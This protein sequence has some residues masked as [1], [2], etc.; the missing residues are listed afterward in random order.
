MDLFSKLKEKWDIIA[1]RRY[2]L[3]LEDQKQNKDE[4]FESMQKI[5]LTKENFTVFR[6]KKVE[7]TNNNNINNN[8]Y[9]FHRN[10]IQH[11]INTYPGENIVIFEDDCRALYSDKA[12]KILLRAFNAILKRK[13]KLLNLGQ[14][15]LSPC[16]HLGNNIVWSSFPAGAQSYILHGD[17]LS[18][19]LQK[20]N[21]EQWKSPRV[22]EGFT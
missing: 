13:W 10:V 18:F 19:L 2:L 6:N 5:G 17:I 8:I 4:F 9:M 7:S 14:V 15:A 20:V 3:T 1:P 22:I 21:P 16:I 12:K 11:A